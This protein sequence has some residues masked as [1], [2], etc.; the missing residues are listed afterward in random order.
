MFPRNP[1][2]GHSLPCKGGSKPQGK[3]HCPPTLRPLGSKLH[4]GQLPKPSCQ[5]LLTHQAGSMG[6]PGTMLLSD[7]KLLPTLSLSD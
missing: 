2:V 4:R 5:W 3:S 1:T 7:T 6:M